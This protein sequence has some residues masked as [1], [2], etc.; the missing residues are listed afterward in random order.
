MAIMNRPSFVEH[1]IGNLYVAGEEEH[2][3][4]NLEKAKLCGTCDGRGW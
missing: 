2:V 1:G 4:G 3:S